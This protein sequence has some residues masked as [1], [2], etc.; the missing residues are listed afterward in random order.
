MAL[1]DLRSIGEGVVMVARLGPAEVV[2]YLA[3]F[4]RANS[5]AGAVPLPCPDC[6]V[7]GEKGGLQVLPADGP[8]GAARCDRCGVTFE[9]LN[10]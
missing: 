10:D 3:A 8:T 9:Y 2:R 1:E 4:D 6:F 5:S 7:P